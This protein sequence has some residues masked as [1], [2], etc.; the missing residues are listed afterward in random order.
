MK[1]RLLILTC[2]LLPFNAMAL[3]SLWQ[4]LTITQ[5]ISIHFG[6]IA[7][8][9]GRTCI[10]DVGGNT[11]GDCSTIDINAVPGQIILSD[12]IG[13]SDVEISVTGSTNANLDFVPEVRVSGGKG[14]TLILSD[15]EVGVVTVKGNAADLTIDIYGQLSLQTDVTPGQSHTVDYTL[16]VNEL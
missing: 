10:I 7:G 4:A 14:G 12:L 13:N 3:S 6:S 5:A 1:L 11:S 15:G 8:R 2:L 9:S 16:T